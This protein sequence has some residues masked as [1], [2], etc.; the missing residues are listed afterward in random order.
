MA[1]SAAIWND[2]ESVEDAAR[3]LSDALYNAVGD[4]ENLGRALCATGDPWQVMEAMKKAASL[5]C[6]ADKVRR[7][8]ML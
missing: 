3:K 4:A 2:N 8:W 5:R 1:T 6:A 7:R